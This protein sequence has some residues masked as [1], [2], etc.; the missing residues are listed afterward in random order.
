[1]KWKNLVSGIVVFLIIL[2][3][4]S[5]CN[6]PKQPPDMDRVSTEAA[7]TLAAETSETPLPDEFTPTDDLATHTPTPST[8]EGESSTLT[9][10]TT[11]TTTPTATADC[12]DMAKFVS[13]TIPDGTKFFPGEK[14]PKTWRLQNIGTCTWTTLYSLVLIDGDDL[15]VPGPIQLESSIK[16]DAQA[17]F[18]ITF[19]APEQAGAYKG[20]W[21]IMNSRGETFGLG[22]NGEKPFW[23]DIEVVETGANLD[24]GTP[25]WID[26]FNNKS[27]SVYTGK[28]N[29]VEFRLTNGA[30]VMIALEPAG[31]QW[32]MINRPAIGNFYLEGIFLTG[33]QCVGKDSYGYI[34][35]SPD[36]NKSLVDSG[37]IFGFSCDGHFRFYRMDGGVFNGIQNWTYSSNLNSGP[38]Q[39]NKLGILAVNDY[40]KIF[41][42]NALVAEYYDNTFQNGIIGLMI[43]AGDSSQFQVNLDQI[44]VWNVP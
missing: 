9:P 10:T 29:Q 38:D 44:A 2:I 30:L 41:I 8:S 13:E 23:V 1:M 18:S 26:T 35:R 21:K 43:R 22:D 11:S 15:G 19:T 28:D 31:D 12:N 16:P 34:V 40:L 24:L 36:S 27:T 42:N 17:E 6:L 20:N 32:R 3:T 25:D 5:G 37:Y 14:F 7:L 4:F 33:N 39:Q